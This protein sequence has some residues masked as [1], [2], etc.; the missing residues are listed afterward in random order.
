MSSRVLSLVVV[1]IFLVYCIDAFLEVPCP[2]GCM[3]LSCNLYGGCTNCM[4]G[5]CISFAKVDQHLVPYCVRTCPPNTHC[6]EI[7][8]RN[9]CTNNA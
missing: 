6:E 9:I 4:S 3:D 2:Q 1:S 7:A 8:G 5:Y